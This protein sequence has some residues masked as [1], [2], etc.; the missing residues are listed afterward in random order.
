MF[1]VKYPRDSREKNNNN[2]ITLLPT[3]QDSSKVRWRFQKQKNHDK[4]SF[5][6]KVFL[7]TFTSSRKKR[8][9][10]LENKK[11]MRRKQMLTSSWESSIFTGLRLLRSALSWF[12]TLVSERLLLFCCGWFLCL[13][14][15]VFFCVLVLKQ[16]FFDFSQILSETKTHYKHSEIHRNQNS[17]PIF[18]FLFC[19]FAKFFFPF[20]CNWKWLGLFGVS[21]FSF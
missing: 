21:V 19:N 5:H 17:M 12:P 13:S 6:R 3:T 20:F 8:D 15:T 14:W 2:K 18:P 7:F 11:K 16:E 4:V 1:L 9:K 10:I